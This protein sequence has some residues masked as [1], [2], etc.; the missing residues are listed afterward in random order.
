MLL[1]L[2]LG[3]MIILLINT[4]KVHLEREL[5]Q[6]EDLATKVQKE[7][8]LAARVPDGYSRTFRLPEKLGTKNY[9]IRLEENE[10]IV[11]TDKN[12]YW[13]IIP[14]VNGT[15]TKGVN[16]INKSNGIIYLN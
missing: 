10:V 15:I 7:V 6:G 11:T 16:I 13:R 8:H 1:F 4:D 5:L 3:I 2:F 9:S 12:E 14:L